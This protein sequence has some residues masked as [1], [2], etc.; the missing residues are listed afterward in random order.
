VIGVFGLGIEMSRLS[1]KP[2]IGFD[3]IG[4]GLGLLFIW[5]ILYYNFPFVWLNWLVTPLLMVALVAIMSGISSLIINVSNIPRKKQ[6]IAGIPIAITQ[7]GAAIVAIYKILKGL[8]I[9]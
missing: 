5:A 1:N 9:I 8:E 3:N 2:N 4:V 7:L 6:L